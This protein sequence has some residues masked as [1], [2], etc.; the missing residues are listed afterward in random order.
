MG[1]WKEKMKKKKN[2]KKRN[3]EEGGSLISG[4]SSSPT[5]GIMA[6]MTNTVGV[7][8]PV[9]PLPAKLITIRVRLRRTSV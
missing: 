9:V 2:K 7:F 8:S 1:R 6:G 4:S 3:K 5:A